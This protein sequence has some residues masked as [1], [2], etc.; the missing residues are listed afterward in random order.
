MTAI[1]LVLSPTVIKHCT[2]EGPLWV[3]YPGGEVLKLGDELKP[4]ITARPPEVRF[5]PVRRG[6]LYTLVMFDA[7][8]A[9]R[10]SGVLFTCF[11]LRPL[12]VLLVK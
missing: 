12:S 4:R 5:S 10:L 3:R 9:V 8:P 2:Q 1:L 7:D 11:R 6:D